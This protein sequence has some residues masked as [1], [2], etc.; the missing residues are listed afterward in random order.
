MLSSQSQ[1]SGGPKCRF[2]GQNVASP[3]YVAGSGFRDQIRP[4]V[5]DLALS[6][7]SSARASGK[8][9]FA[10]FDLKAVI[11]VRMVGSGRIEG[12]CVKGLRVWQTA[13]NQAGY[14]VARVE[15]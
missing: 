4:N 10:D 2:R 5:S 11:F 8:S 12:D 9:G 7:V 1:S 14:I 13:G 6:V 15:N 3:L